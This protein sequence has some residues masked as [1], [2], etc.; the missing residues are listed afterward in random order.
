MLGIQTGKCLRSVD[1][2]YQDSHKLWKQ[3]KMNVCGWE[4]TYRCEQ[5]INLLEMI[6]ALYILIIALLYV[7]IPTDGT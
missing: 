5:Q 4:I 1:L 3:L 7:L 6:D 2:N